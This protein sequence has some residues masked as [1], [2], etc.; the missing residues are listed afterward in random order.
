MKM[1]IEVIGQVVL[2]SS[3]VDLATLSASEMCGVFLTYAT[4]MAAVS[5][6]CWNCAFFVVDKMIDIN[7]KGSNI[8]K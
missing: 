3:S 1:L 2:T 4:K 6:I 5:S 7:Y 8:D